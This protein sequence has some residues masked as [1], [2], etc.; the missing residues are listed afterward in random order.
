MFVSDTVMIIN[1]G[2]ILT[3]ATESQSVHETLVS[4]LVLADLIYF[5]ADEALLL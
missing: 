5:P 3:Q 2:L 4:L 1:L